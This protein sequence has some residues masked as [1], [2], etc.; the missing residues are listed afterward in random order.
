MSQGDKTRL[1][2]SDDKTAIVRQARAQGFTNAEI[3]KHLTTNVYGVVEKKRII[4]EW[5]L[6]L[7]LTNDEAIETARRAAIIP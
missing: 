7:D 2:Y 5:A 6:A 3:L 4:A 1:V